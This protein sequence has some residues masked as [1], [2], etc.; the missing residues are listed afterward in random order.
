MR[1]ASSDHVEPR[2]AGPDLVAGSGLAFEDRGVH[3]LKGVPD[4]WRVYA[5]A[6]D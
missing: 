2:D 1:I 6:A 3:T 5:V 4:D